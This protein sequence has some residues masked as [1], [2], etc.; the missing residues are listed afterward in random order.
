MKVG[1]KTLNYTKKTR[2]YFG[3]F[4]CLLTKLV[5]RL[6][7]CFSVWQ[8]SINIAFFPHH[9]PNYPRTCPDRCNWVV[10]NGCQLL[11]FIR[12]LSALFHNAG[13]WLLLVIIYSTLI[14][15]TWI[16]DHKYGWSD[17]KS[18][19]GWVNFYNQICLVADLCCHRHGLWNGQFTTEIVGAVQSSWRN[20]RHYW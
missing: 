12:R 14:E 17:R 16:K 19:V 3:T 13:T 6:L 20:F 5:A 7:Q 1:P 18:K 10:N 11:L 2:N 8:Y 9:L 15:T 4:E